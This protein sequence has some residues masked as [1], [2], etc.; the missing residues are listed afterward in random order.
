M[1]LFITRIIADA[2]AKPIARDTFKVMLKSQ[3]LRVFKYSYIC[4]LDL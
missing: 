2:L 3:D 4:Y 1:H